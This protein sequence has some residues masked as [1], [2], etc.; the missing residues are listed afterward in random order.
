MNKIIVGLAERSY[1]IW[2]GEEIY[3]DLGDALEEVNFP[4]KVAIVTN[5]TVGDLYCEQVVD[6]L[7][8]SGRHVDVIRIPD[9]EAYK[10]IA[11]L[12][13]IFDVLI[14]RHFDR[15]CGLVA[16]GGGVI[17]DI[18]GFAAAAYLRGIQFVQLPTT[19]LAQVDSSVGGKTGVNHPRGKNL[20]GAFYQP[21]DV[22]I[23]VKVLQ[24]LPQREYA[25]GLAEV[26]KYGIIRD[27]DF[28]E[29]METHRQRLAERSADALIHAVMMSCQIKANV[30][31]NDEKEQGLRALLNLGHTFGHAVETLAGYGVIK[32]GEAVSIGMVMAARISHKLELCTMDQVNRITDLLTYFDLP[33]TPPDFSVADYLAVMQRDKKVR[34]GKVRVVLNHGLGSASLHQ[35][36]DLAVYLKE[37][38]T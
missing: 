12:E 6:E 30:V 13:E 8:R 28:F 17:G 3:A 35:V 24:T 5:P 33:V 18:T 7:A 34:D 21:R 27:L 26:V 32:H 15:Y 14:D 37:L 19:L 4:N 29:W 10:T 1:P 25:A 23:D 16:L 22:H 31:E 36:D 38:L 9:G 11:T 2:I 20:I